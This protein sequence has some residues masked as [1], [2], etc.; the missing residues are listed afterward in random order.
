MGKQAMGMYVTNF[1]NRMDKTAYILSYSMRPLVD[2]RLMKYIKLDR[3][4]SGEVVMVAIM[5]YSGYNQEDS[6]IFNQ[7]AIDRGMFAATIYHTE[8]DEDKK[9]HGD[10]EI[11]CKPDRTKT[12]GMKFGNYDKLNNKG[13]VAENTLLN[14]K[15]II[16]G[17]IVPIKENRNDHTKVIKYQD[18]SKSYRTNEECYVD[19][20]Y[21]NC[22]V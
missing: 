4:P 15:D 12:K 2:T 8:K 9:I 3:I 22:K 14:N 5:S 19:K 16:L 7:G 20:N 17:K 13:V 1:K 11:R 21:V 10:E 18:Q 6:I